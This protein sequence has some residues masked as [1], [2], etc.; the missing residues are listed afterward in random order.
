MYDKKCDGELN[1]PF[2][3]A[4]YDRSTGQSPNSPREQV[5]FHRVSYD[6]STG[7]SSR[8]QLTFYIT[9]KCLD[10]STGQKLYKRTGNLQAIKGQVKFLLVNRTIYI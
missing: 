9:S 2:Y 8:E 3:R 10:R 5:N 7:Q 6:R 4:S 1:M